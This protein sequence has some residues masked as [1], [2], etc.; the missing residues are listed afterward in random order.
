MACS[1]IGECDY[2]I[3]VF[4]YNNACTGKLRSVYCP[5]LKVG[6]NFKTPR[7]WKSIQT[8]TGSTIDG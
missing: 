2:H 8:S 3:S 6:P 4:V 1:N 5:L 7:A